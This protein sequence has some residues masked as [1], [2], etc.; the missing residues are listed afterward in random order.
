MPK[1]KL[2]TKEK[3]W[4][5]MSGGVDSSLS[6]FLLKKEGYDVTGVFIKGWTPPFFTC[7]YESDR[8]DALTVAEHIGIPFKTLDLGEEYKERVIDEMIAE[9]KVGRTPNPDVLC[10]ERVKFGIFLEKALADGARFVATGHYAQV[11]KVKN[12]YVLQPGND[13]KKDQSYFL[14]RLGQK[15]LAH[16]LFPVGHLEKTEVRKLAAKHKLATA[17]KKDSQGLCFVGKLDIKEFLTHYIKEKEGKVLNQKGEVIGHHPGSTFFTIGERHGFT[18]T[19]KTPSDEPYYVV[20]KDSTTNTITVAQ[21]K[22]EKKFYQSKV[23]FTPAYWVVGNLPDVSKP[24]K[25]RIRYREPL[26]SCTI[27]KQKDGFVAIFNKPRRAVAPGQAIVFYKGKTC[28][29]GGVIT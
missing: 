16:T 6:A 25:A 1:K 10:N 17:K 23:S 27:K 15:E 13:K 5:A 18:I 11:K 26:A 7:S 28:L 9:Y 3:V 24:Y 8:L 19:K 4:M 20:A 14:Y 12:E 29:G 21:K 22:E 2:F